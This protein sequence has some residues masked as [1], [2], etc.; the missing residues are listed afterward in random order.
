MWTYHLELVRTVES[1][2][3]IG[4][5]CTKAKALPPLMTSLI[6]FH[7]SA[8]ILMSLHRYTDEVDVDAMIGK[9]ES[10]LGEGIGLGERQPE[11]CRLASNG[12]WQSICTSNVI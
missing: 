7:H 1:L 9:V 12:E 5:I 8:D 11:T 4:T 6:S 3:R 10:G 2:M